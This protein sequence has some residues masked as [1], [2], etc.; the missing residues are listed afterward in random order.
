MSALLVSPPPDSI[1][2]VSTS[3]L[4][5]FSLG[6]NMSLRAQITQPCVLEVLEYL[7]S[8]VSHVTALSYGLLITVVLC[9]SVD[10][11]IHPQ[12]CPQSP[13][14]SL[15]RNGGLEQSRCFFFL[16]SLL[17]TFPTSALG[18]VHVVE[19]DVNSQHF[20]LSVWRVHKVT[21]Q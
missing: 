4:F 17:L 11:S 14:K 6:I 7:S 2:S 15:S 13:L 20:K 9:S 5:V 3:Y 10:V 18:L 8:S 16:L 21:Q 19:V 1:T 12:F